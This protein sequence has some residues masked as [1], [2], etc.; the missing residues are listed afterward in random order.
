MQIVIGIDLVSAQRLV[1][2]NETA[3]VVILGIVEL[4]A[5]NSSPCLIK[6]P[7]PL[8]FFYY[9]RVGKAS[10]LASFLGKV[11]C[12]GNHKPSFRVK[13]VND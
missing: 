6:Q 1:I 3:V 7:V 5:H 12:L 2:Y 10:V 11:S 9:S 8:L 13:R 4:A